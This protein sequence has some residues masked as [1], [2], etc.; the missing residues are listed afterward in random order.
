MTNLIANPEDLTTT[1][2][3]VGA[4]INSNATTAPDGTATADRLID[5]NLGGTGT[6]RVQQNVSGITASTD[7]VFS[8]FLKP[9]QLNWALLGMASLTGIDVSSYCDVAN[10][11]FGTFGA[12]VNDS[13]VIDHGDWKRFWLTFTNAADTSGFPQIYPADG[14]GDASV[15]HDNT[16]SIFA[17]GAVLEAGTFPST[18]VSE[19]GIT[20]SP[21]FP[22]TVAG[23]GGH[24]WPARSNDPRWAQII[25]A[26]G[27]TPSGNFIDDVH[28][29]LETLT[30]TTGSMDD[31]WKKFKADNS[32]TDTSEPFLY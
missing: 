1:W 24:I 10:G 16:S 29:A 20:V 22:G 11:V 8:V 4:V 31:L 17:W 15:D 5:D 30:S 28:S 9:D 23:D 27:I 32:V 21:T 26:S 14:D 12:S 18:Y 6:A 19:A 7:F 3:V 13:G 25:T 2:T